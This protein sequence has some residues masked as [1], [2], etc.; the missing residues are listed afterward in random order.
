MTVLSERGYGGATPSPLGVWPSV[1]EQMATGPRSLN[2]WH[3]TN[4]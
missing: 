1:P 3:G 2:T 4:T